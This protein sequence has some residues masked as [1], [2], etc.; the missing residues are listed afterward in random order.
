MNENNQRNYPPRR[1]PPARRRFPI[2]IDF[3]KA[4]LLA[5]MLIAM[6]FTLCL[7]G[8]G[9]SQPSDGGNTVIVIGV[10]Y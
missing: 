2:N 7:C 6:I 5:A 4:A 9:G 1:R 3:P 8:M 10:G